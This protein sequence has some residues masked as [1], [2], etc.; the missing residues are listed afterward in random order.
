[1]AEREEDNDSDA[2][3][4]FT[5]VQGLQQDVELRKV[6]RENKARVVR[7]GKERRRGWALKK[8]PKKARSH[9]SIQDEV[10]TEGNQGSLENGGLLP[11][12]IVK[13][14]AAREKQVFVS[15]SEEEKE[16][17]TVKKTTSKKKKP[18]S[19]GIEPIILKDMPP[20]QCLQNSLEFLKKR[21]MLVSRSSSV[22]NNSNQ[23]LRLLSSSG[24][25]SK[26]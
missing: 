21:K 1:M 2:P 17:K 25:L 22:L 16:E 13:L 10:E 11:N 24:V 19:F 4:E 26:K 15:D 8:T 5:S 6:Q 12:D 23:A 14:L 18:K 20:P 7:E 9:E 3:E